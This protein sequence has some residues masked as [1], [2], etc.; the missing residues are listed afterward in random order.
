MFASS[1]NYKKKSWKNF[2]LVINCCAN[3]PDF[4]FSS[5]LLF[6]IWKNYKKKKKK[7]YIVS[8]SFTIFY[9]ETSQPQI[10]KDRLRR[11]KTTS[12]G[13]HYAPPTFPRN[14]ER[15]NWA[16]WAVSEAGRADTRERE[17]KEEEETKIY[18]LKF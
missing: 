12:T 9:S 3:F 7:V 6:L 1:D 18:I 8:C 14:R 15:K 16:I 17:R 4:I 11:R 5:S 10:S 2:F 13:F